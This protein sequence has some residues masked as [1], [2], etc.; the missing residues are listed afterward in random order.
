VP[1][2]EEGAVKVTVAEVALATVAAT[3]VGAPGTTFTM[4]ALRG[5]RVAAGA[6]GVGRGDR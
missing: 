6:L 5:G 1:P 4:S 2:L 3:L